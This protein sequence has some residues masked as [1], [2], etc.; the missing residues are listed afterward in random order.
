LQTSPWS[1]VGPRIIPA[2]PGGDRRVCMTTL[3]GTTGKRKR[4]IATAVARAP[5]FGRQTRADARST[6]SPKRSSARSLGLTND[7]AV[8]PSGIG[9]G[10]GVAA[11][12]S[13]RGSTSRI[14]L[15]AA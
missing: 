3:I 9:G 1:P 6:N 15:L 12:V 4:A 8:R 5:A 2:H 11:I 13:R 10:G 14:P 7:W